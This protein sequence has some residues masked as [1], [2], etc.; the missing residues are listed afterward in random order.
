M[1][2]C[3]GGGTF[4]SLLGVGFFVSCSMSLVGLSVVLFGEGFVR[5][6]LVLV[7]WFGFAVYLFVFCFDLFVSRVF[8]SAG[9]YVVGLL[10]FFGEVLG[11][12]RKGVTLGFRIMINLRV[13]KLLGV[14]VFSFCGGEVLGFCYFLLEGLVV[15]LQRYVFVMLLSLY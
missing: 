14:L 13:G 11:L 6:F 15:V 12:F 8:F 10:I 9:S 4:S 2:L 7:F 3:S 1:F 5:V